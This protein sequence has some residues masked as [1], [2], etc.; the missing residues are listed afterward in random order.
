MKHKDIE[1]YIE[2]FGAHCYICGK[3]VEP[4]E[5]KL[6]KAVVRMERVRD[7]HTDPYVFHYYLTCESCRKEGVLV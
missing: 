2:N 6:V 7:E 5:R 1:D 4:K 3:F